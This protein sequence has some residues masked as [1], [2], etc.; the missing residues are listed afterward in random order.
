MTLAE[1][2]TKYAPQAARKQRRSIAEM[3]APLEQIA[4]NSPS[5]REQRKSSDAKS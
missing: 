1:S 5:R 2:L 3:F 4:A